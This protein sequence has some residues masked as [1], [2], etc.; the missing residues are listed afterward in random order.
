ML[1]PSS[2]SV[3]TASTCDDFPY[4]RLDPAQAD[5]PLGP[6]LISVPNLADTPVTGASP[7]ADLL[8]RF[9]AIC[10]LADREQSAAAIARATGQPI[11]LVEL[12]LGLRRQLVTAEGRP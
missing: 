3:T 5:G 1:S 10:D 9:G 7:G 2:A 12:V 8:R 4:L 6:T 11:G